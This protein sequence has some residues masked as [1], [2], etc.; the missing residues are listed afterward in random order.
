MP[1]TWPSRSARRLQILRDGFDSRLEPIVFDMYTRRLLTRRARAHF[2]VFLNYCSIF[3]SIY[4]QNDVTFIYGSFVAS[5]SPQGWRLR[6]N[7][8]RAC[9]F[10]FTDG[11]SPCNICLRHNG[12]RKPGNVIG[13]PILHRKFY[14][15]FQLNYRFVAVSV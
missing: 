13:L 7:F 4:F 12:G 11:T 1:T 15:V 5:I 3:S 6:D 14:C 8:F 2:A 9:I 10:L